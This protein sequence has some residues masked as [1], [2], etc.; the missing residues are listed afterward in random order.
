[1]PLDRQHQRRTG[2]LPAGMTNVRRALETDGTRRIAITH[3]LK[4]AFIGALLIPDG[5]AAYDAEARS[6]AE[7]AP[8]VSHV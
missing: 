3:N 8:T 6:R 4:D 1:M 2:N 7:S 5:V